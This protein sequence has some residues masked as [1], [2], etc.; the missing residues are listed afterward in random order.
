MSTL[1][2]PCYIKSRWDIDCLN[3]LLDSVQSQTKQFEMVY[4]IDDASSFEYELQHE[5][6]EHIKLKENRGPARARNFGI[7]KALN[8]GSQHLL[9]TDHDCILDKEWKFGRIG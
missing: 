6:I 9:F 2:I 8:F 3:R 4:L 1:I 5:F 7:D